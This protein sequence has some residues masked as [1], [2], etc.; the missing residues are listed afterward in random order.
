MPVEQ[1]EESPLQSLGLYRCLGEWSKDIGDV[2][3]FR[4]IDGELNEDISQ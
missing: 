2:D 4:L 1:G 3:R